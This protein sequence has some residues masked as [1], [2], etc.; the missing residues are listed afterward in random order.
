MLFVGDS[1]SARL[2][3]VISWS[4]NTT[5]LQPAALRS[6]YITCAWVG[7]GTV[8]AWWA[9]FAVLNETETSMKL[10]RTR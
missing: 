5:A 10:K 9:L 2:L 4:V 8:R 3:S 7:E 6:S 1:T